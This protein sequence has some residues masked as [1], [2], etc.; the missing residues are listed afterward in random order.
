MSQRKATMLSPSSFGRRGI[1]STSHSLYATSLLQASRSAKRLTNEILFQPL[2]SPTRPHAV[3]RLVR[4]PVEAVETTPRRIALFYKDRIII[5]PC[6]FIILSLYL[7]GSVNGS[8]LLV[9]KNMRIDPGSQ[10]SNSPNSLRLSAT[11]RSK[12]KYFFASAIYP[13]QSE[14]ANDHPF[15]GIPLC[16]KTLRQIEDENIFECSAVIIK[17]KSADGMYFACCSSYSVFGG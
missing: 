17:F 14:R 16:K 2:E 3:S 4:D 5:I 8:E 15:P 9:A 10:D 7:G 13:T 6:K 12:D 1:T 11:D